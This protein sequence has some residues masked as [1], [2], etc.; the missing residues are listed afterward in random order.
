MAHQSE[1]SVDN[2]IESGRSSLPVTAVDVEAAEKLFS[3]LSHQLSPNGNIDATFDDDVRFDLEGYLRNEKQMKFNAGLH[4]KHVDVSWDMTV[5][6]EADSRR[7][8]PTFMDACL[9]VFGLVSTIRQGIGGLSKGKQAQTF[10]ILTDFKGVARSGTMTLVLG[11][12]GSGCTTFLKVLANYRA[13]FTDISGDVYYNGIP[14]REFGDRYDGETAYN[15]EDDVF[16]PTLT[17]KQVSL[18]IILAITEYAF[19]IDFA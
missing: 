19:D 6:G 16:L 1:K 18:L 9:D 15:Q 8:Q 3:T 14:S 2:D 4:D 5:Q 12:P 10:N 13:G 17:V 11:R 7:Y